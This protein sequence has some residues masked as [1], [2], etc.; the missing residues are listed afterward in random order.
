[1]RFSLGKLPLLMRFSSGKLPLA[2][3]IALFIGHVA[4]ADDFIGHVAP[5][6]ALFIGQV[7]TCPC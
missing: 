1:M 5:A 7:A 2:P 6:D 4:P 3:A